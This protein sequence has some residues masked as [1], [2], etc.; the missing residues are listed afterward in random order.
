[1]SDIHRVAKEAGVSISTVSYVMSGK[2]SI[3]EPTKQRVLEAVDRLGYRPNARA[4]ML[5]SGRTRLLALSQPF[6][7]STHAPTYMTFILE[8]SLAAREHD[9]DV[10]L[11]AEQDAA[12]AITRITG[13]GLT[14]GTIA[15]DVAPDDERAS[16]AREGKSPMVFIGI[17]ENAEGL[18]C[19]DFDFERAA[20]MAVA[21][22][23]GM[24]HKRL[25]LVGQPAIAYQTSHFAKRARDSFL[26]TA[27]ALGVEATVIKTGE[28]SIDGLLAAEIE[29]GTT[30]LV[31]HCPD[32]DLFRALRTVEDLGLRI[33]DDISFICVAPNLDVSQ[34]KPSLDSLPLRPKE[35]CQA[36]VELALSA[37][38][39][40]VQPGVRLIEPIYE[41]MGS[42]A[43]KL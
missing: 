14:E 18:I 43:T 40:D 26:E 3:S 35:T 10:V 20:A 15:L 42:V 33:P 16:L 19:V 4:S 13:S 6:H 22:M 12:S 17:P 41:P 9:Y 37:L 29:A 36:A 11:L 8:T 30:G 32:N 7:R 24:G 38:E 25:T 21:T 23:V 31:S 34:L 2:R 39:G 5:A 27:Q 1:M 28:A